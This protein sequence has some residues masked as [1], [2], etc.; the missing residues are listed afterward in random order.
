MGLDV[1][2]QFVEQPP[3]LDVQAPNRLVPVVSPD[4]VQNQD[5][6]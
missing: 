2:G 6:E 1:F 3:V 5:A 4:A